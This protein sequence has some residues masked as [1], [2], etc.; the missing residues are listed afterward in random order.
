MTSFFS[1]E[2]GPIWI[3]ISQTGREWHVDWLRWCVEM[4]T[5]CRIST[6]RTFGRIQWHVI[7]RAPYLP[8]CK[9]YTNF[10]L[11]RP[12]R[13]EDDDPHQPQAPWPPRSKIKVTW[14]GW[15]IN[16]KRIVV[17]SSKLA[18]RL[19]RE[20]C[21]IARSKVR[22]AGRLTQTHK[23]CHIFRMVRPKNFKVVVRMEDVDPH[24]RQAPW[25]SRL[26]VKVISAIVCTS[27]LASS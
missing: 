16:R 2:G 27:H 6:W 17:I 9:A 11:G 18:G 13:M 3:K 15:P 25:P 23:M 26:K 21:Y 8:N 20:V 10:K 24:Q 7:P 5:R 22:V 4:E 14:S 12:I 19:P 1:A